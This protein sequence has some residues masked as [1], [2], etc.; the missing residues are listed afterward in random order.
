[1]LYSWNRTVEKAVQ[2]REGHNEL[3]EGV[4]LRA[5]VPC[6]SH[7]F[8]GHFPTLIVWFIF[9]T[10]SKSMALLTVPVQLSGIQ[11]KSDQ[12][13]SSHKQW[14]C[15]QKM[16]KF[17]KFTCAAGFNNAKACF[18]SGNTAGI[19]FKIFTERQTLTVIAFHK[20]A[21]ERAIPDIQSLKDIDNEHCLIDQ[22]CG[23][24][25]SLATRH[26]GC[27]AGTQR[28]VVTAGGTHFASGACL[29]GQKVQKPK[30]WF[31]LSDF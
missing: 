8:W 9:A 25:E 27:L 28:D 30:A 13:S 3:L 19:W 20:V 17:L 29:K 2:E 18:A 4:S 31:E 6:L 22:W 5:S 24:T 14:R 10:I 7:A 26:S 1:M 12:S 23:R 11:A 16:P 15:S 21:N